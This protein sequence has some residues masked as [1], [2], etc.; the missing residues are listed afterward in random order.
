ME[1]TRSAQELNYYE[2]HLGD[3]LRD[4][5]H[6]SL[7]EDAIYR[8]LLDQYYIRERPL[9]LSVDE[10]CKLARTRG[11][12]ERDAVE[13]VLHSFFSREA[14]GFHQ[15]RADAEIARYNSKKIK[16]RASANARWSGCERIANALPTQSEGNALQTP[17][18]SKKKEGA[19]APPVFDPAS[20]PGLDAAAWD[21]WVRH[22]K[23]IR[24]AIRPDA[25]P[26][27]AKQ[28]AKLGAAQLAE[29]ERA[30]AGGWQGLHP[31][32]KGKATPAEP[33]KKDPYAN[34]IN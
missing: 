27:A 33:P 20:V 34:C 29:V 22:R 6:L 21:L 31:A 4:T 25:M 10:C 17:D 23:S 15:A 2:H 7:V 24:K 12:K 28:L 26:T 5:A 32:V 9:P 3:Y 8:R 18:T 13:Y 30:V 19:D 11:D 1:R 14:D 16:A